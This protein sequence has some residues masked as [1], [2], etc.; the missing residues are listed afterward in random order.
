MSILSNLKPRAGAK[1]RRKRVGRGESSGMGKT[2]T[3]GNKGQKSRTSIDIM[4]G[5]EGGQMPLHRRSPKWGF[6]QRF[7]IRYWLVNLQDLNANFKAGE[8]V[9]PQHLVDRGLIRSLKR[10]VKIL[11]TGKL[12]HALSVSAHAFSEAAKKSIESVK[13]SSTKLDWV[14]KKSAA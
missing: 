8:T 2:S 11:G 1:E 13:G 14:A 12:D 5:F 7:R 6:N 3:R 9:S 10:P 4:I